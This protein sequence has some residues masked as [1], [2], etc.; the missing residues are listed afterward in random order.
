M[1]FAE[2]DHRGE[3]D[4]KKKKRKKERIVRDYRR[5]CAAACSS[6]DVTPTSLLRAELDEV[7]DRYKKMRRAHVEAAAGVS[8]AAACEDERRRYRRGRKRE[9]AGR[10]AIRL[11]YMYC[12]AADH[13]RGLPRPLVGR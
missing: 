4:N 2:E 10:C 1:K 11:Q 3:K 6:C 13:A 9:G 12:T 5:T 7:G 8:A